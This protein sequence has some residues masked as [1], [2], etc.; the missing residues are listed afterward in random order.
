MLK[1]LIVGVAI[2]LVA[3]PAFAADPDCG[4][5]QLIKSTKL[6]IAACIDP[7]VWQPEASSGDQEYIF[8]SKDQRAGFAIVTED[9][10]ASADAYRDAIIS[11]A[12]TQSGAPEGSITPHDMSTVQ[13]N[14]K[15]WHSMHYNVEV[16]ETEL[17]FINYYY[18][19]EG[20]GAVQF[21]FWS[22][23][24]DAATVDKTLAGKVMPTVTISK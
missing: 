2:G 23:P 20:L 15:T 21:I 16:Q 19:E 9:V 13:L 7:A 3:L 1:S 24:E 6:P 4:S 11:V 8:F 18:S 17:E 22:T 10:G 5:A 12:T 14:G